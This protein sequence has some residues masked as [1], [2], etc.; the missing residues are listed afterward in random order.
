M[1]PC[2]MGDEPVSVKVR[3]DAGKEFA[4]KCSRTMRADHL[5]EVEEL[6]RPGGYW[7]LV[8]G[9]GCKVL[10]IDELD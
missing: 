10:S 3:T 8:A 1:L 4:V 6:S 7:R 9:K 2:E 5:F